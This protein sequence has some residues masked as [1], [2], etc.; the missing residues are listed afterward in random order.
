MSPAV[1]MSPTS[2]P[3][4]AGATVTLRQFLTTA[5]KL[6]TAERKLLGQRLEQLSERQFHQELLS[7]FVELRDLHTNYLL[8]HPYSGRKAIRPA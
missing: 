8:P 2:D 3:T 5:G 6:T 7:I 4:H 1:S